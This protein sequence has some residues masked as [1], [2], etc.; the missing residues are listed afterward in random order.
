MPD[1]ELADDRSLYNTREVL[2]LL[3]V[4]PLSPDLFRG[5]VGPSRAR[6]FGGQLV[7]QAL[8]AAQRTTEPE[9]RP[10]VLHALFLAPGVSEPVDYVVTRLTDGGSFST[11]NVVARQG[12]RDI[13][14]M[15][16]S[17]QRPATGLEHQAESRYFSQPPSAQAVS[18]VPCAPRWKHDALQAGRVY[19]PK[20]V[21]FF[22]DGWDPYANDRPDAQRLVWLRLAD[23]MSAAQAES[24][25]LN[26]ALLAY[27]SDHLL[28]FTSLQT[29]GIGLYEPRLQTA[30]LDHSIWFH[31]PVRMDQALLMEMSSPSASSERGLNFSAI[32]DSA[33][34]RIATVAQEALIRIRS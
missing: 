12:Q 3:S 8:A 24:S 6:M 10:H 25:E 23:S 29:H 27:V 30:S 9:R 34:K 28:L 31:H 22:T 5:E 17:F 14:Q 2:R 15:L 33:G 21:E 18:L 13:F 20:P 32:Y 26:E 7:A 16:V 4:E 1:L 19:S 11:R